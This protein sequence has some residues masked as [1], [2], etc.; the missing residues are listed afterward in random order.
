MSGDA[1]ATLFIE[2]RDQQ[3]IGT[4]DPR[5]RLATCLLFLICLPL[6]NHP[7]ALLAA[8][9]IGA[10]A[11]TF[12][13]LPI[14]TIRDRL[15]VTE[16]FLLALLITLPFV[17][18]GH[19]IFSI[20]W[21]TA[22]WEGLWRAVSIILRINAGVLVILALLGGLGGAGLASA[23]TGIG[24]PMRLAQLL[25][26]TV[27]YIGLF[28]D[29]YHRLR[30]AMRVRGF[31]PASNRHSWRTLGN[32]LGMLLVRSLE[33]AERVRWAMACRGFSGKFLAGETRGL[34]RSDLWF[35]AGAILAVALLLALELWA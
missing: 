15:L 35:A 24:I 12:A 11:V 4:I 23:M 6:L 20:F 3:A 28:H 29:E 19:P 2:N 18:P 33:R 5:V 26:M 21:L 32:L 34:A 14:R 27:R 7:L 22:S 31:R 10:A 13:R 30:R 25:Q 16:G 1:S 8:V 9:A 17:L